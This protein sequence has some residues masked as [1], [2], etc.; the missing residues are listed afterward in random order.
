MNSNTDSQTVETGKDL[1]LSAKHINDLVWYTVYNS[2][3]FWT[4]YAACKDLKTQMPDSMA[5]LMFCSLPFVFVCSF[6]FILFQL[7]FFP[8]F[9]DFFFFLLNCFCIIADIM[10][11]VNNVWI[12]NTKHISATS[13]HAFKIQT[14]KILG[15]IVPRCIHVIY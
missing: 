7:C 4:E 6:H 8:L 11:I 5:H 2:N 15:K 3:T 10:S 1:Y 13:A 12:Q 14:K 9:Q